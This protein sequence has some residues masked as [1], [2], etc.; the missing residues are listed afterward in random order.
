MII[1]SLKQVQAL[2][3]PALG[4][5]RAFHDAEVADTVFDGE[6]TA[7]FPTAIEVVGQVFRN[8]SAAPM[9][10]PAY[11]K[12]PA[13]TIAPGDLY[14]SDGRFFYQVRHKKGTTSY[15]PESFER[16]IYTISFTR[17]SFQLGA[18]FT[19]DRLFYFR[20]I[21]NNVTAVWSVIFEIGM[22]EDVSSPQVVVEADA[23]LTNNSKAISVPNFALQQI[24]ENM[25]VS[26]TGVPIGCRVV[27]IDLEAGTIQVSRS[28]TQ[29]GSR[30]LTFTAPVGPN[31]MRFRWLPP[32]LESQVTLTE[33]K[34]INPLGISLK[35]WGTKTK[36]DP[37][38]QTVDVPERNDFG[39]E[40][41][42]KIYNNAGTVPPESLPTGDEFLLRVRIG[43]FDVED[44]VSDAK[45]YAAYVVRALS[46]PEEQDEDAAGVS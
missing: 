39:Y 14:G 42:A 2:P 8:Q 41:L 5:L 40:G 10:L 9:V 16:S 18:L 28:A 26:G 29:S 20:L 32:M 37:L 17:D 21:S 15:Y 38:G 23:V 45:G 36:I 30:A 25:G 6:Q 13:R 34:S 27:A 43:Q 1:N 19:L 44:N 11:G 24:Q 33:L 46:D 3:N 22:R 35:K 31:I 4:L 7:V 12:W